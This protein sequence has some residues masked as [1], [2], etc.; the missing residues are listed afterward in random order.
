MRQSAFPRK[1]LV[2][3]VFGGGEFLAVLL[4]IKEGGSVA[5]AEKIR[6]NMQQ[7]K[8]KVKDGNLQKT[9]SLGI[10][11]SPTDT[12]LFWQAMKFADVAL[13]K[14]K[15]GGRNKAVWFSKDMWVDARF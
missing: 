11:E 3:G 9:I 10:S 12:N 14:A 5:V 6:Q 7:A 1:D 8:F 4:D 13:Y 15:E 2:I